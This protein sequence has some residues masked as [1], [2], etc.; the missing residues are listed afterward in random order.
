MPKNSTNLGLRLYST[1]DDTSESSQIWF[2]ENFGYSNSNLT[3]I[4]DAI[5][6]RPTND[7]TGA[8]GTWGI[9]ISGSSDSA[10][11]DGGGNDINS[12]YI[13][14]ISI[15]DSVVTFTKGNGTQGTYTIPLAEYKKQTLLEAH[16]VGNLYMSIDS[17]SPAEMFGGTWE[18]IA[19]NRALMGASTAHPAGS[20]AEAGLPNITGS[21]SYGP[22]PNNNWMPIADKAGAF[23]VKPDN[24]TNTSQPAVAFSANVNAG[25]RLDFSASY[26]SSIYGNSTT[27]QP[28]AYYVYIWR[29]VANQVSMRFEHRD[30]KVQNGGVYRIKVDITPDDSFLLNGIKWSSSSKDVTIKPDEDDKYYATI[31]ISGQNT[32][33]RITITASTAFDTAST[34]LVIE[35]SVT[36]VM[37][38]YSNPSSKL[39]RLTS[40]TDP[41]N[42]VTNENA[43]PEPVANIGTQGNYNS[44]FD[45]I[46][47]WQG[48]TEWNVTEHGQPK[49]VKWEKSFTTTAHNVMVWIPK[50]YYKVVDDSSQKTRYYYVAN[51]PKDGFELHPGSGRY[52]GKYQ[53]G[54]FYGSF[55]GESPIINIDIGTARTKVKEIGNGWYVYDYATRCAVLLLYLVEFA[56]FNSNV[57]LGV[58]NTDGSSNLTGTTDYFVGSGTSASS[59]SEF[60]GVKYRE[61]ENPY[62]I[63]FELVD[64]INVKNGSVWVSTNPN[65]N[66]S[67]DISNYINIGTRV[68]SNGYIMSLGYSEAAPWVFYPTSVGASSSTYVSAYTYYTDASN[69]AMTVSGANSNNLKSIFMHS[70][71]DI[72][73]KQNY[74]STRIMFVPQN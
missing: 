62:S 64:G 24:V 31:T 23:F 63:K 52:I 61:I 14:D 39:T 68:K 8:S 18:K 72:N 22:F 57:T 26:S 40:N 27:V 47:P 4:D 15:K 36:G 67:T 66:S 55:P 44:A 33:P 12:T 9:D 37:W 49:Y 42:F 17:T 59:L 13:S 2:A 16:P 45:N 6:S 70:V 38:N 19:Q 25:V 73:N 58:G 74:I 29:K 10:I 34:S 1:T 30:M 53:A 71:D 7:G 56:N 3:K 20:T 48:M 5:G 43:I 69:T 60:G 41:N 54:S 11:H 46:A 28:P 32:T 65:N 51:Y 21:F 50:F 35:N